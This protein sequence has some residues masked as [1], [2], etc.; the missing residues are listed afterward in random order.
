MHPYRCP[1]DFEPFSNSSTSH[2]T[3]TMIGM[4]KF[5]SILHPH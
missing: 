3:L 1:Y 5:L 2:I 4:H